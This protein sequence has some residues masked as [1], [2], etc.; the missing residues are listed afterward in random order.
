MHCS[1]YFWRTHS[2]QE[3]DRI[4][5][6]DGELH[7]YEYKWNQN[8]KE[9]KTELFIK[10]YPNAKFTFVNSINYLDFIS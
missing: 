3:I 8:A 7:A 9:K 10:A 2:K 4:E 5:E 6:I 1:E